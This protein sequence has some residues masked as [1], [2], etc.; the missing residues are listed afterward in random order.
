MAQPEPEPPPCAGVGVGVAVGGLVGA[1]VGVG[2]SVGAGVQGR[3][4]GVG[5]GGGDPGTGVAGGTNVGAGDG[6]SEGT[7][8]ALAP[9]SWVHVLPSQAQSSSDTASAG[10]CVAGFDGS[11][12]AIGSPPKS[13]SFPETLSKTSA[14]NSTAGG[15]AGGCSALHADPFHV[16]VPCGVT[17]TTACCAGSPA[18]PDEL[19]CGPLLKV[20]GLDQAEPDHVEMLSEQHVMRPGA[21]TL[22]GNGTGAVAGG[23][24]TGTG[25]GDAVPA[26]AL[27]GGGDGT[28]APPIFGTDAGGIAALPEVLEAPDDPSTSGH[29]TA[30]AGATGP[31]Q[32]NS[33]P[34][35]TA[36]RCPDVGSAARA[37]GPP[38]G[39]PGSAD[40]A[41][42]VSAAQLVPLHTHA[43]GEGEGEAI[44]G[45]ATC[46]IG[47]PGGNDGAGTGHAG[48]ITA[49][50][51]SPTMSTCPVVGSV[52]RAGVSPSSVVGD[53]PAGRHVV[54]FHTHVSANSVGGLALHATGGRATPGVALGP[55]AVM[56]PEHTVGGEYETARPPTSTTSCAFGS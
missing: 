47:V 33:M 19:T 39:N 6:G 45:I 2:V 25:I 41:P 13:R 11:K 37:A 40:G 38:R 46:G 27:V 48:L 44:H 1:G 18:I 26:F 55:P 8:E 31:P 24:P 14:A 16:H 29:G 15:D 42:A 52:P 22:V 12:A 28:G 7:G 35:L 49:A 36:T 17:A 3:E 10:D 21:G 5:R 56:L 53:V 43:A 51:D 50:S 34:A 30:T 32:G 4:R 9:A 23:S 20:F 54:P